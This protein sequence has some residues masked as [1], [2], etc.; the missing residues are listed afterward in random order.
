[1]S[2]LEDLKVDSQIPKTVS[3]PAHIKGKNRLTN[4]LKIPFALER[5]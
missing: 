4:S 3:C 5:F 2:R 1:M